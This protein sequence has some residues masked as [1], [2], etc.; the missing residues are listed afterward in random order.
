[1]WRTPQE[2]EAKAR[3]NAKDSEMTGEICPWKIGI[4]MFCT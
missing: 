1:M 4:Q 3:G 2:K